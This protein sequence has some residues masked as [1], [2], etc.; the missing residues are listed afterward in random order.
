MG[1][2]TENF[3]TLRTLRVHKLKLKMTQLDEFMASREWIENDAHIHSRDFFVM[4]LDEA[5]SLAGDARNL[6]ADLAQDVPGKWSCKI[7][8]FTFCFIHVLLR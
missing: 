7:V 1:L 3:R 6:N 4:F 2:G 8:S 5:R